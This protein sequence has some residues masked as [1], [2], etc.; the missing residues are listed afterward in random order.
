MENDSTLPL[1][2]ADEKLVLRH[3]D[4]ISGPT[5]IR[6][7][8]AEGNVGK[9][10]NA[11]CTQIE[12]LLPNVTVQR[13]RDEDDPPGIHVWDNIHFQMVPKGPFLEFFLLSLLGGEALVRQDMGIDP[14]AVKR[15]VGLPVL[16]KLYVAENCPFCK[17]TLP[18]GLFL[19]GAAPSSIDLRII[20]ATMFPELASR[21]KIRSVPVT[22]MDDTFRWNGVFDISEVVDMI[23]GRDPAQLG[24]DTLKKMVSDGDAQGLANLM[25]E[26]NTVIPAFLDLLVAEKWPERLGAMVA[27]EYLAE[28]NPGLAES[29]LDDLW[30]RFDSLDAPVMGDVLHLVGVYHR[31]SQAPRVKSVMDGPYPD[32]VKN[33]AKEIFE[34]LSEQ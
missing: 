14:A 25:D 33:V 28:K 30:N 18:K 1:S 15:R 20:D 21:D 12:K 9:L 2:P 8:Y 34:T 4:I 32:A 22:V 27:F 11:F 31:A 6:V 17:Q 5:P 16:L 23:A 3:R 19:A 29:V 13:E 10:L 7:V 26:F 24:V